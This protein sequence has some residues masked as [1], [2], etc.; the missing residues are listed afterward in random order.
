MIIPKR[1]DAI[2]KAWL[3]RL[4]MAIYDNRFLARHLYFKGGTCAA[5]LGF[6]DRF[7]VDLDFDL[8]LDS[9]E[10]AKK[11]LKE[12][13]SQKLDQI[14]GDLEKIFQELGL[15]VKDQSLIFPQY[16][17]RYP[18]QENQRNTLKIDINFPYPKANKYHP[19]RLDEIDRIVVCQTRETMF[20]NKLVAAIDRFKK[21]RGI[22]GRD[23]YDI[24]HFFIQGFSF[25]GAVVEELT[26]NPPQ[27]FLQ[28]LVDFIEDQVTEKILD[29]DLNMLLPP[30]RFWAARKSLKPETLIFLRDEIGRMGGSS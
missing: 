26:N 5:M 16:F 9:Q 8:N 13:D 22:A 3:Y 17:L 28:E 20:A 29:Q 24:H 19:Q 15:E 11:E 21:G 7:S 27:L 23:I 2:H 10:K 6:L 18:N 14:K 1:E 12:D 30:D 25:E 4:L